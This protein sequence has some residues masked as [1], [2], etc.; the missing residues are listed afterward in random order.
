MFDVLGNV[1][2][3]RTFTWRNEPDTRGTWTILS[4]CLITLSLCLWKS[5]HLNLPG[6]GETRWRQM[7][8][9]IQWLVAGMSSIF[10]L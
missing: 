8:R 1:T 4:S 10:G 5:L 2:A 3:T 7:S 9:K 6:H